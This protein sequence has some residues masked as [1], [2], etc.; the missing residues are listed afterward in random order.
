MARQAGFVEASCV[1]V[2]PGKVRHG[3]HGRQGEA[4]HSFGLR[5]MWHE[6]GRRVMFSLGAAGCVSV[7]YGLVRYGRRVTLRYVP[8]RMGGAR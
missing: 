1:P 3:R 8:A 2:R 6:Y 4:R 7:I 5:M